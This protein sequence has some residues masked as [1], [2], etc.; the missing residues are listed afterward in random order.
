MSIEINGQ[1]SNTNLKGAPWCR[2]RMVRMHCV[3]MRSINLYGQ[4]ATIEST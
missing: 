1:R 2:S 3:D 4:E